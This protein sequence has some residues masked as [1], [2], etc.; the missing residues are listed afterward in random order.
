MVLSYFD[1]EL[2]KGIFFTAITRPVLI[3]LALNT[4]PKEPS[5]K[6]DIIL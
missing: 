6:Y 2:L 5:P 1:F 3:S 4:L